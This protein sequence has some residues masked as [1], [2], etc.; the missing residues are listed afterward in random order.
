MNHKRCYPAGW[1]RLLLLGVDGGE[2]VGNVDHAIL[3][4]NGDF[5]NL[6]VQQ[7]TY[8]MQ[9]EQPVRSVA[10]VTF[11]LKQLVQQH[12]L[13]QQ[14]Q[15]AGEVSNLTYH[16][17]GHV[18]FSLKDPEAQ[19]SCA[20]FRGNAQNAPRMKV[21]DRIIATGG[22]DIYPPR[23]SYQLIV[24]QIRKQGLGD[25]YQQFLELKEK[26]QREG[27]FETSRKQVLP[28]L[29][30][31]IAI[32]TSPTGAAVRDIIRTLRRRYN[33]GEAI[34]IPTVVQGPAGAKSIVSSLEKA[35]AL[36][37]DTIILGR[38]GG[39]IEDLWNFNEESVARAVAACPIPIVAGIG[40]ESDFTI[41]DFVA[42]VRASTPTAAAEHAAPD[43]AALYHTLDDYDRQARKSLQYFIDFKR[44]VLDDYHYRL[45][46]A[47]KQSFQR[48]RHELE[49]LELALRG[50]DIRELLKQGYS[51]T[52]KDGEIQRNGE[53]IHPGDEIE[54]VF[55]DAR[56]KSKVA[57]KHN[58]F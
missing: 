46:M 26:L 1:H 38:G 32:I 58:P 12:P 21:G 57:D 3:P 36:D 2:V 20:L 13:L 11:F 7:Q 28:L 6:P 30:R 24:R 14:I 40:H 29:P 50:L 19:I 4:K 44:Q 22:I 9:S 8:S 15:V 33:L 37:A 5:G 31:K 41:V 55:L 52:L 54:T 39:S 25:L 49:K 18:Y 23:G 16:S 47:V 45:E 43:K 48:K 53:K 56:L 27:L 42:D 35:I 34:L 51:L 17:S 10:E